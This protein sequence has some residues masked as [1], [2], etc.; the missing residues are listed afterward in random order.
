VREGKGMSGMGKRR[1][2]I[3][4]ENWWETRGKE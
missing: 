3:V 4:I 2:K 1:R